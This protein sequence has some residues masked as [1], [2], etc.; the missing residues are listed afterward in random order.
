VSARFL[1]LPVLAALALLAATPALAPAKP[2]A[3]V[4]IADQ[5]TDFF[6]DPLFQ[7][8]GIEHARLS[9][10]WD[11]LT[12]KWQVEHLDQW[13]FAASVT[14]VQPLVTWGPSRLEG[15]YRKLPSVK[16]FVR[17]FKKF[18]ARYPFVTEFSTWNEANFC[19][20]ATC[21]RPRLVARWYRALK[22]ACPSCK[23]LAADLLDLGSMP[24]WVKR[25]IRFAGHQPRY[26]GLHNYV[27]AN[28]FDKKRTRQL[29]R[30][31]RGEI[32]LTET[33]GVVRRREPI[34]PYPSG[35]KHAA[36][37][38]RFIFKKLIRVS[39]RIKRVYLYQWNQKTGEE[40]WDSGL[41]GADQKPRP[42]LGVLQRALGVPRR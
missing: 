6:S 33:G 41:I 4:G 5:K 30:V 36:K 8:L 25:F 35:R 20:Q 31:T 37:V 10:P 24:Q 28:R 39:P 26:W 9:L 18:R 11:A 15:R 2:R 22:K 40:K 1:V 34:I 38:T 32:W 7:G 19:G 13:M 3:I 16:Q 17:Q 12:S 23:I 42:A 27:T 14:G 29:L 21:K